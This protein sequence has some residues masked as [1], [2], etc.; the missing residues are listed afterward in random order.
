MPTE[1]DG[2]N[3]LWDHVPFAQVGRCVRGETRSRMSA[4]RNKPHVVMQLADLSKQ[5][6][7]KLQ[8]SAALTK[9]QMKPI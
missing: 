2:I 7:A 9:R 5:L 1:F 4:T 6:T 3:G 8:D